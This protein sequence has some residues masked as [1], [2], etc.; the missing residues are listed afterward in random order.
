MLCAEPLHEA[1]AE[2]GDADPKLSPIACSESMALPLPLPFFPFLVLAVMQKSE[3]DA[4]PRPPPAPTDDAV[5]WLAAPP[6]RGDVA[7]VA[8]D[9]VLNDIVGRDED[10]EAGGDAYAAFGVLGPG[11]NTCICF[12]C[13]VPDVGLS[14]VLFVVLACCCCSTSCCKMSRSDA[15]T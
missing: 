14:F 3:R 11:D 6:Q 7:S 12:C 9:E 13:L 15:L 2:P 8:V 1:D 5:A 4:T 10:S